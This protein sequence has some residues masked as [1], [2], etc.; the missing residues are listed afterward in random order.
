MRKQARGQSRTMSM[1]GTCSVAVEVLSFVEGCKRWRA[2]E[3]WRCTTWLLASVLQ[4]HDFRRLLRTLFFTN[5]YYLD[6]KHPYIAHLRSW[7]WEIKLGSL[8]PDPC[9]QVLVPVNTGFPAVLVS[10]AP[11][12]CNRCYVPVYPKT[13]ALVKKFC[14]IAWL[15][16]KPSVVNHAYDFK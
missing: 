14:V 8:R 11:R 16:F 2:L 13:E 9:C 3:N 12:I 10:K 1:A 15:D 5:L 7:H 4:Q 6:S